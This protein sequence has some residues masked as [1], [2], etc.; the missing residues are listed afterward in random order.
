MSDNPTLKQLVIADLPPGFVRALYE[1]IAHIYSQ[2]FAHVSSDPEL[3]ED[4]SKYVLGHY[5]RGCAETVLLRTAIEHGLKAKVI[6]PDSGGC[7]HVKIS[8]GHFSFTMCHV[9]T[10]AGFPQHSDYREQSSK[11]NQHIAQGDLFP[12]ESK[13]NKEEFYGIFVHSEQVGKKDAFGS[14]Y[15]GFPS[16]ISERW[17]EEPTDFKDIIDIQ[18]K[19]FQ[20]QDD[21]HAAIQKSDPQWKNSISKNK[22]SE[23]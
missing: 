1:R 18:Q 5:R 6:Q 19:I 9:L 21:P 23:Q 15:I 13:P 3:G 2:T 8:S 14:L 4:Q 10:P 7:K 20:G 16:P 12:I 17:I 22:T 11:I